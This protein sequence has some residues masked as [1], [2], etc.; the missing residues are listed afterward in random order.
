MTVLVYSISFYLDEF[1][2]LGGRWKKPGG[3][4]DIWLLK[5][6]EASLQGNGDPATNNTS[7]LMWTH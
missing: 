7:P 5:I 2:R 3:G 6:E 4:V 1:G